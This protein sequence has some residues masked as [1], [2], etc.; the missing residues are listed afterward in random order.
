[1]LKELTESCE[2]GDERDDESRGGYGVDHFK[3]NNVLLDS[4]GVAGVIFHVFQQ[5]ILRYTGAAEVE[6]FKSDRDGD[7]EVYDTGCK[8]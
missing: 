5:K 1:M 6:C 7:N 2:E 8:M 4:V 3:A